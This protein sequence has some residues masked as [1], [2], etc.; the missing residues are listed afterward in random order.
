MSQLY[1]RLNSHA[2]AHPSGRGHKGE[3]QRY[4]RQDAF[5]I[6]GEAGNGK[7]HTRNF[8]R[9]LM[10]VLLLARTCYLL[11]KNCSNAP[12]VTLLPFARGVWFPRMVRVAGISVLGVQ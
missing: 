9:I 4:G 12:K 7:E 3:S 1:H 2:Q 5:G 10:W 6:S 8:T 11:P